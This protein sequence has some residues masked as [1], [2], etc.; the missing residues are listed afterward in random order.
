M[1][2]LMTRSS[3]TRKC[4]K[5]VSELRASQR[6]LRAFIYKSALPPFFSLELAL[7]VQ[8]SIMNFTLVSAN[9]QPVG[10]KF[11]KFLE[12]LTRNLLKKLNR[13]LPEHQSYFRRLA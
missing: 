9:T 1:D 12:N 7:F 4:L 3:C 10:D 6:H 2:G 11:L 8:R 5:T 13:T